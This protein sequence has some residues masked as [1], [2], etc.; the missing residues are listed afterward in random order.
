MK[1]I[2]L[3]G[4]IACGKSTIAAWLRQEG[5]MVID[6]DA[7]S[8]TLTAANGKALPLIREAFGTD[9]F[10]QDGTLN[11]GRL[12]AL[13]FANQADMDKLNHIMQPLIRSQIEAEIEKCRKTGISVVVLEAPLLYEEGLECYTQRVLCAS[14]PQAVQ[15]ERLKTRNGLTEA[16]ALARI[17]SQWPLA[18]KERLA[19]E[20]IHTDK[21]LAEVRKQALAAYRRLQMCERSSK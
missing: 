7:I 10:V 21:A 14:A 12:A 4:G 17:Q 1:V 3:T 18:E 19:D 20:T 5:A 13:V 9:V 8:R 11:R 2:G 15:V 6:A 16:Q